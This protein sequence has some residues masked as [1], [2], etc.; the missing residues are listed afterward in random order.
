M[1]GRMP[2]L[3][4]GTKAIAHLREVG[5]KAFVEAEWYIELLQRVPQWLKVRIVPVAPLHR[6]G[7]HKDGAT[8]QLLDGATRF[9][10]GV[11]HVIRRDHPG[12][13]QAGGIR[14]AVIVEPVVVGSGNGGGK[15]RV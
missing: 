10:N 14:P 2:H 4:V 5:T 6:I 9:L 3:Q 13:Q 12:S 15:G 1:T 7:P 11:A 8:P